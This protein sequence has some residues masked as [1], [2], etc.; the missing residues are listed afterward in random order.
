MRSVLL[1]VFIFITCSVYAITGK[2]IK[3]ADGDTFTLLVGT[4][5]VRVRLA[6][7]DCPEKKQPYGQVARQF[8]SDAIFGKTIT[9]DEQSKDRYG[10]TIGIVHM[11]NGCILNEEL[12]HAG[13]AW[14]YKQYSRNKQWAWYEQCARCAR[15]GLWS[16]PNAIA[17][18]EF[19]KRRR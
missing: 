9:V 12:L 11:P 13:L 10:R 17:P 7:I 15:V 4:G 6:G 2:V 19:R 14:H 1:S 3:I 16:E 8:T 18:W 5:Q